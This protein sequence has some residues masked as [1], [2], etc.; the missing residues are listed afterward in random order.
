MPRL[1]R[2]RLSRSLGANPRR[3]RPLV[4]RRVAAAFS[5]PSLDLSARSIPPRPPSSAFSALARFSSVSGNLAPTLAHPLAL[6]LS[7]PQ[8]VRHDCS[9]SRCARPLPITCIC[10]CHSADNHD[11]PDRSH[12]ALSFPSPRPSNMSIQG[13]SSGNASPVTSLRCARPSAQPRIRPV[14]AEK[15]NV[16][17]SLLPPSACLLGQAQSSYPAAPSSLHDDHHRTA[18]GAQM[19]RWNKCSPRPRAHHRQLSITPAA[20]HQPEHLPCLAQAP[21]DEVQAH[22]RARV[23]CCTLRL[24]LQR[25]RDAA[26]FPPNLRFIRRRAAVH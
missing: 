10:Q 14:P 2:G 20:A 16:T 23:A 24:P 15:V 5:R 11:H 12:P 26:V 22:S 8:L 13:P 1:S 9:H 4:T 17:A 25:R 6:S 18:H 3:Q 7:D 19:A 21:Y